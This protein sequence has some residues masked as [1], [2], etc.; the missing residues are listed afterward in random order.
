MQS[1]ASYWPEIER[2]L[3]IGRV[4]SWFDYLWSNKQAL[5][6]DA[7]LGI[8]LARYLKDPFPLARNQKTSS[9]W[10]SDQLV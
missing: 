5:D 6:E 1:L 3:L 7:V 9:D 10:Q 4:I 2:P 8:L